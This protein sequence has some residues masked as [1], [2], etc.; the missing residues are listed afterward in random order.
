[1]YTDE[2]LT[3]LR[4]DL[5]END[6]CGQQQE[7]PMPIDANFHSCIWKNGGDRKEH[8]D[9]ISW[10]APNLWRICGIM[11]NSPERL[12]NR[13]GPTRQESAAA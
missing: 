4:I 13:N 5:D 1:M 10:S 7:D 3:I 2:G 11:D 8:N 6:E 9:W 12:G